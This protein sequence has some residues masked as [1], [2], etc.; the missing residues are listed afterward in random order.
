[1]ANKSSISL[2]ADPTAA[3]RA[4]TEIA[5][6]QRQANDASDKQQARIFTN[7]QKRVSLL[8]SA[9][10]DMV[11]S[12]KRSFDELNTASKKSSDI[13]V[14]AAKKAADA[15]VDAERGASKQ[16]DNIH[17]KSIEAYEKAEKAKT[18]AHV[19]YAQQRAEAERRNGVSG[20][21]R[22]GGGGRTSF[23][24][25]EGRISFSPVQAG[26]QFAQDI[27]GQIQDARQRRARTNRTFSGSFYQ[28]GADEREAADMRNRAAAFA[29]ANGLDSAEL[30]ASL[31]AAQTEFSI[32]GVRDDQRAAGMS[33]SAARRQ[34][35]E[36]ALSNAVFARNTDQ[37]A[38]EVLRVT[39]MLQQ[40]G[41]TGDNQR[42]VMLA[43]TGMAQRGAV[44]LGSVTRT[45]L[46]PLQGRMAT[47]VARL[48]PGATEQQRARAQ[49]DAVLQS[50]AE[51]EVAKSLGQ[52]PR[53][54]GNVMRNIENAL[55]DPSVQQ[56]VLHNITAS[57]MSA[58]DKNR[59]RDA[60]FERGADGRYTMRA[61][62]ARSPYDFAKA[63]QAGFG[64]NSELMQNVL[65]G[66]GRGNPQS[67]QRNWRTMLGLLMGGGGAGTENDRIAALLRGVGS[68]F[69][70]RDVA[71]G[72]GIFA[73]DDVSQLN[74]NQETREQA[75]TNNTS[76]LTK[77]S[78]Q[79]AQFT[80]NNPFTVTA[81][82]ALGSA[83]GGSLLSR[84]GTFSIGAGGLGGGLGGAGGVAGGAGLGGAA[85]VG[86]GL[87]MAGGSLTAVGATA[88]ILAAAGLAAAKVDRDVTENTG[89][90]TAE[91]FRRNTMSDEERSQQDRVDSNAYGQLQRASDRLNGRS[92][93]TEAILG[94][95][96]ADPNAP[97]AT[98]GAMP[99]REVELGPAT[100]RQLLSFGSGGNNTGS[101]V[102]IDQHDAEFIVGSLTTDNNTRR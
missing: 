81:M 41:I 90:T 21:S 34:N 6:L 18:R 23:S 62:V 2:F 3:K 40:A 10:L 22:G 38:G 86:G 42:Q 87:L 69:T 101:G 96:N 32:L 16:I 64:G 7:T 71:R 94:R 44:E 26:R 85:G 84:F 25:S 14:V 78:N 43:L 88:G 82:N 60:M 47:A 29:R 13:Q 19:R 9:Y 48:G 1:M 97:V 28:A 51:M 50:F 49:Q 67:L 30:A 99:P 20:G 93:N 39:G 58:S 72:A 35:L 15:R 57:S 54:V 102:R 95:T 53:A 45:A 66:G 52:S 80:A 92:V 91:A 65:G 74:T 12:I 4:I 70:E 98:T 24:A 77:L 100:I 75:L 8:K 5:N 89:M 79:F 27:H 11:K 76:E 68:D 55:S 56:R 36:Q 61:N 83:L 73:N 17:K 59:A 33:D 63:L 37:D 31:S 46:G